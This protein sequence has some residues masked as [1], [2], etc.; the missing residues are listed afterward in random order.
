MPHAG[1]AS[2][3]EV[4]ERFVREARAAAALDHPNLVPLYEAGDVGSVQYLASAYCEGPTLARWLKEQKEPVAPRLAARLIH[5]MADAVQH[6]HERGVLHRDLKPSNVLMQ[7]R[8]SSQA[9]A[10]VPAKD[11]IGR[12]RV[13]PQDHRFR[14]GPDDGPALTRR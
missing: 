3:P 1:A 13:R 10:E 12:L 2:T 14:P 7:R 9:S 8:P 6:A 11:C 5:D 4:K